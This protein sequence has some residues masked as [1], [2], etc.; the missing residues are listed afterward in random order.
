MEQKAAHGTPPF[1]FGKKDYGID[2][3]LPHEIRLLAET[4]DDNNKRWTLFTWS[5]FGTQDLWLT[6]SLA[7]GSWS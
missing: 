6:S 2:H 5:R 7:E 4:I 3:F 1:Y